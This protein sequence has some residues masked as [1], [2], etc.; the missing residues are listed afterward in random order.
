MVI[1]VGNCCLSGICGSNVASSMG[2]LVFA[3]ISI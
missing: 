1:V 2:A 3:G